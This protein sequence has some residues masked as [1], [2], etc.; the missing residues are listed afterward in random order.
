LFEQG[1]GEAVTI[2]RN[3]ILPPDFF[4]QHEGFAGKGLGFRPLLAVKG[5]LPVP[6]A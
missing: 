4:C 6:V 5:E 1:F 3:Q 2:A